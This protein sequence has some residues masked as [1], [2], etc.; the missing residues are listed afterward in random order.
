MVI[1]RHTSIILRLNTKHAWHTIR[2]SDVLGFIARSPVVT[3]MRDCPR[4]I[5]TIEQVKL[6]LMHGGC[7]WELNVS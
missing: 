2:T 5:P 4:D 6:V 7:A 1:F 3:R